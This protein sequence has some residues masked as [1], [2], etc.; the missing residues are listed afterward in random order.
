MRSK[1]EKKD[2][3]IS[4][5]VTETQYV[6]L[7]AQAEEQG[8]TL[9]EYVRDAVFHAENRL[10]PEQLVHI[11]NIVNMACNA[12]REHAPEQAEYMEKEVDKLW[13]F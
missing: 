5:R 2:K 9:A 12:I 11:Q 1:A 10:K 8:L 7:N 13:S 6:G 4:L 3:S